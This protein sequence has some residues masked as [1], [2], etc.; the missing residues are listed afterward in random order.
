MNKFKIGKILRKLRGNQPIKTI[1]NAAGVSV[2]AMYMYE[3]GERIPRDE[4]KKKLA[5]FYKISVEIF[6]K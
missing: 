5:K 3:R 2:S 4:I 6:F 1:A